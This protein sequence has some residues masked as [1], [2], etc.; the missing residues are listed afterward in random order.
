MRW[1]LLSGELSASRLLRRLSQEFQCFE[2]QEQLRDGL[3]AIQIHSGL[4]GNQLN[5]IFSLQPELIGDMDC[6]RTSM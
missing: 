2:R 4:L 5:H 3:R 1:F 6:A